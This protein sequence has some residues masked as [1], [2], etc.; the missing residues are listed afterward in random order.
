[1]RRCITTSDNLSLF[2][3]DEG[4]ALSFFRLTSDEGFH[5]FP[6]TIYRQKDL[7][8]SLKWLEEMRK[9]YGKNNGL[10]KY[11]VR[12]KGQD[13]IIGMGGLTP[14]RFEG[15]ELTDITYRL[16]SGMWGKGLGLE[17]ATLLMRLGREQ[18]K[19]KNISATITPDNLPS[20]S[21]AKK[22]GLRFHSR[23][24]LHGVPTDLYRLDKNY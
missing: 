16:H 21:I 15:E 8:S 18:F 19:L 4:D 12:L 23:I 11:A 9:F 7:E 24:T 5:A 20:Q 3:F 14:W 1:M 6:I 17:L 10:G 13:E 22:I 2:L